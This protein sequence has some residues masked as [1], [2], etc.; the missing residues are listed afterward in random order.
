MTSKLFE[1]FDIAIQKF[2]DDLDKLELN[3]LKTC[4]AENLEILTE[5][6]VSTSASLKAPSAG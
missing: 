1:E 2:S 3:S 6:K 5:T 4:G